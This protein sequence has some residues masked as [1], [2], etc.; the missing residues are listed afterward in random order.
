MG[1]LAAIAAAGVT[2]C[3]R[4]G[5]GGVDTTLATTLRSAVMTLTLVGVAGAGGRWRS[6]VTGGAELDGRAWSFIVL[7][8]FCGAASWLAYFAALKLGPA[9]PVAALDRLSLPLVFV[10]GVGLLGEKP[11]AQ[12]WIGVGL[13]TLGIFLIASDAMR[14]AS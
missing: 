6:V 4:I 7:A 5:L 8:G 1:L 14:G 13:A 2:I 3:G 11:G 12:G 10:L 9:G